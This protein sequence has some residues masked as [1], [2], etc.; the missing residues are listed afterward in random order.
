MAV[1][2]AAAVV[3]VVGGVAVALVAAQRK[4]PL[5]PPFMPVCAFLGEGGGGWAL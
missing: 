3:P 1:A 5:S 4:E 2:A